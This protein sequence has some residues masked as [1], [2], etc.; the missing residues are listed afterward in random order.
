MTATK[1]IREAFQL[2]E[3]I[4]TARAWTRNEHGDWVSPEDNRPAR[5]SA[6]PDFANRAFD[7]CVRLELTYARV[8][9]ETSRRA[10]ELLWSDGPSDA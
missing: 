6:V 9:G 2:G 4:L 3:Q 7:R 10:S 5:L 8:A 1:T